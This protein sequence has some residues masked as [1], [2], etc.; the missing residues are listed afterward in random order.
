MH[1][2]PNLWVDK[3]NKWVIAKQRISLSHSYV[4]V[5]SHV[6]ACVCVYVHYNVFT[7]V[8]KAKVKDMKSERIN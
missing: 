8:P 2:P 7:M 6:D 1:A 4:H 3:Y 5:D